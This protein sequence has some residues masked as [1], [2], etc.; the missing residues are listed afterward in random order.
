MAR[1][2]SF[3]L[4]FIIDEVLS[5]SRG[6]GYILDFTDRTFKEFFREKL[7][8]NIE[9]TQFAN[10]G[11]SKGKRL[12]SFIT[13]ESGSLVGRALRELWDYRE[14]AVSPNVQTDLQAVSK[15]TRFFRIVDKLDGLGDGEP[16]HGVS[17]ERLGQLPSKDV[18]DRL[19]SRLLSMSNQTPQ[20]RGFEF[21]K[22]L[23]DLFNAYHLAPRGSFRLVGEQIDGS[24][25]H[26]A[27]TVLLEAKW[28]AAKI[29]QTDLLSFYGKVQGKAQWCSGLYVSYSGF[30]TDGLT[31]FLRGRQTNLICM[32]GS[33]LSQVLLEALDLADVIRKK[34]RRAAETN[35]AFVPI[36]DLG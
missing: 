21:E 20:I 27:H 19:L 7:G 32:D 9:D 10:S 13:S 23:S 6:T 18:T 36:R 25:E 30:S 5:S 8:V 29:G 33:D 28:Q 12:R 24:F 22:F 17:K 14:T 16:A 35:L 31:A 11:S 1:V 34:K 15:R 3:E 26:A 4:R 2:D